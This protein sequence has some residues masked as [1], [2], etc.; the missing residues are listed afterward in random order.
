MQAAFLSVK[1][2]WLD[3]INAHKRGLAAIYLEGLKDDFV[4]PIVTHGCTDV[5][6]IFNVRHPRRDRLKQFLLQ[7]EIMTEIHYPIPPHRQIALAGKLLHYEYP[8][9]EEIHATT[10]SLPISYF[11]NEGDVYRIVEVMN[12]F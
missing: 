11:H 4:K 1:L 6:H 12:S 3:N 7:N 5:Y 2:A 8:L 10:L 9:S